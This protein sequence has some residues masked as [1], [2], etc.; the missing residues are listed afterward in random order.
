[1]DQHVKE[2]HRSRQTS[3]RPAEAQ[4]RFKRAEYLTHRL[5][6]PLLEEPVVHL[7]NFEPGCEQSSQHGPNAD[8]VVTDDM[9]GYIA[10]APPA[11]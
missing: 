7:A 4:A 5:T 3:H 2:S 10:H 8:L 9:R 6:R 11:T 1:M